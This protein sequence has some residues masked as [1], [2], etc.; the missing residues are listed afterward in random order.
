MFKDKKYN[1]TKLILILNN[2]HLHLHLLSFILNNE[3]NV[4]I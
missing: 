2:Q 3:V 4:K 1:Q